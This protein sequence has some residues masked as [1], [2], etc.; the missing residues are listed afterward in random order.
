MLIER[1]SITKK[2]INLLKKEN[3]PV[4][5]LKI[6]SS[7]IP[8]FTLE[9]ENR[10]WGCVG[11]E[12]FDNAALLRSLYVHQKFRGN[13]YG[14]LLV[15]HVENYAKSQHIE[16]IFLLTEHAENFFEKTGY[17]R[18]HRSEAPKQ[19][20]KTDQFSNLCPSSAKLMIKK[21]TA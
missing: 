16:S 17:S 19:I 11:L 12:L 18:I 21:L 2:I 9:A 3:L 5:D 20:R 4:S 7:D 13:G 15:Q 8:F 14:K 6:N 10:C 1:S